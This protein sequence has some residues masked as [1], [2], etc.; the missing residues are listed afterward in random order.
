MIHSK[1][2][3]VIFDDGLR[4]EGTSEKV[5]IVSLYFAFTFYL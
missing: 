2:G 5:I 1:N 3:F 4:Q